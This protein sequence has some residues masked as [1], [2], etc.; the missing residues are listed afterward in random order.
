MTDSKLERL[1]I[2]RNLSRYRV[3]EDTGIPYPTMCRLEDPSLE[4]MSRKHLR[5]LVKYF[6]GLGIELTLADFLS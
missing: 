2:S 4:R 6:A 3:A 5:L 1:R